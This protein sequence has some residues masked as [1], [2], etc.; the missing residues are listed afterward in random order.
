MEFGSAVHY[1]LQVL[2]DR[3]KADPNKDFP[4][5]ADFVGLFETEMYKHRESFTRQQYDRR[6]EYG[7]EI[8]ANYYNKYINDFHKDVD[9][10][11]FIR[12]VPVDGVPLKGKLDKME[13]HGNSVNVVDYKTGKPENADVKLKGPSEKEP[14][15]GDYWRQAVFYKLLVDHSPRKLTVVSTEFDFIEPDEAKQFRKRKVVITPADETTVRQ[16]IKMAWE[17]IQ[18]RDFFTGCGKP[19]CH[20][21]NFV[22]DHKLVVEMPKEEEES[23]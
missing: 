15:G 6:K 3:M 17:R 9:V 23:I 12:N 11:T 19:D 2:F 16:Q 5:L 13:K 18:A 21:C 10:E 7:L 22:K 4:P 20:W 14:N 8:L 1:A